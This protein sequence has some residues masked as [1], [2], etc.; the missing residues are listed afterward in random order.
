MKKVD[1]PE[2]NRLIDAH[3]SE[4]LRFA[5]GVLG[6]GSLAQDAVQ[7]AFEALAV[8]G[9]A[10]ENPRAWL[11][12]VTRTRALNI[13]R[14]RKRFEFIGDPPENFCGESGS[15]EESVCR[16]ERSRI[17][18]EAVAELPGVQRAVLMLRYDRDMSYR[19]IAAVMGSSSGTVGAHLHS[20]LKNLASRLRKHFSEEG[21]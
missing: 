15:P 10:P 14:S 6:D 13:L 5:W 16:D 17:L 9:E 18:R 21:K 19:E 1:I 7:A 3:Q 20:A 11:Y 8:R 2:L 12:K 4:L